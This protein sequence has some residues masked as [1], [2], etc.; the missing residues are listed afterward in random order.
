MRKSAVRL[1][2]VLMAVCLL[3][4]AG[5]GKKNELVVE[6][7]TDENGNVVYSSREAGDIDKRENNF[8]PAK[9]GIFVRVDGTVTGANVEKFDTGEY[10]ESGLKEFVQKHLEEYNKETSKITVGGDT[11]AV[12]GKDAVKLNSLSVKNDMATLL[13]D[14]KSCAD[15][16]A[17]NCEDPEALKDGG[18]VFWIRSVADVQKS[19]VTFENMKTADGQDVSAEEIGKNAQYHVVAVDFG[20]SMQLHGE[21]VFASSG[22][23]VTDPTHVE[24][25][26]GSISYIIFK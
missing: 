14:Y 16:L 11:Y 24:T 15:Y 26:G 5:C 1:L 7:Y 9:A 22:V 3:P 17:F 6:S 19:G 21:V 8:A 4:A 2:A 13:L 10:S 20:T 12:G 18:E 23:K 25:T